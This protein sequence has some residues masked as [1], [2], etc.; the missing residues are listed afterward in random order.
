MTLRVRRDH[1]DH[2]IAQAREE[3]PNECCG[4]MGGRGEVVEEVFPGRNKDQSPKTYYMDPEDQFKADREIE[5]RGWE[6]V[7][8]YHSHPHTDAYPSKTDVARALYPD[9]RYVIVSL[10]D[11]D[12]PQL[13]AFRIVDGRITEEEVVI[14]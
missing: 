3:A 13:R 4:M 11:P 6:L 2:I 10:R 1:V 5:K 9:A 14:T 7:G 12:T 8:I